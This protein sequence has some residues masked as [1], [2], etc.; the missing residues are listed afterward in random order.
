AM[1]GAGCTYNDLVDRDLDAQVARTKSRPLPSGQVTV[2][3]AKIFVVLQALV[4]LLVLLQFNTFT[5]VL[6]MCSLPIVA[7][8][9]FMKRFFNWPQLVLGMAF[10]WGGL[11]GYAAV[12]G[13]LDHSVPFLV[14]IAAL[15]WT[16]GYDTI[17]AHQDQV[18]DE[19]IGIRSTARTF[20]GHSRL[21]IGLLFGGVTLFTAGAVFAAGWGMFAIGGLIAFAAHLTWQVTT[22]QPD[23]GNRC[24]MLFRAN[25]HAGL[26]FF[27]GLLLQTLF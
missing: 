9:P 26:L 3:Q 25:W 4:G 6:G 13:S 27:A 20:G 7:I 16:I 10:S 14:Y 12:F 11:M 24:L 5:V 22:L 8:Y 21:L 19:L 23:D 2:R 15:L 18:D 17:Y 1:R